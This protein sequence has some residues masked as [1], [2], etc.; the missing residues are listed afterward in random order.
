[1]TESQYQTKIIKKLEAMFP[2]CL[3]LKMDASYQQGIP[4]IQILWGEYWAML[5]IKASESANRQPNQ[6]HYIDKLSEMS[7]AAYIHPENEKEV[8]DALQQAFESPRGAR[9]S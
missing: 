9:V 8:L 2:G 6:D 4:D 5:E 3:I 7:F 1:M